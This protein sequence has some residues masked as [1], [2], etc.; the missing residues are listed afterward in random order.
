MLWEYNS[1]ELPKR[2]VW[3]Y[4][5]GELPQMKC[6]ENTIMH[7]CLKG[8]CGNTT[9][10]SCPKENILR[11]QFRRIA[12]KEIFWEYNS[13]ELLQRSIVEIHHCRVALK[14]NVGIQLRRV[15]LQWIFWEYNSSELPQR[16][17]CIIRL[18]RVVLKE[19]FWEY[20]SVELPQ[21]KCFENTIL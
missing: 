16:D 9:P 10:Q 15:V 3:E 6:F 8:K 21:R 11:I 7:N 12:S 14:Q 5:S 13:I 1:A 20:N 2:K 17:F 18:R 19:I 4:N